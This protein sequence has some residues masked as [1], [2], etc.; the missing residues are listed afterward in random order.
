LSFVR[1]LESR[2]AGQH[3]TKVAACID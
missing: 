3:V 1:C 2:H